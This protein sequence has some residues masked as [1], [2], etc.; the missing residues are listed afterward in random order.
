[1]PDVVIAGAGPAG[2]VAATVLA[3]AGVDVLLVDRAR[4]PRDKLCGDTINPGALAI[5]RRLGLAHRPERTAIRLEGMVVTGGPGV[6]VE[7]RYGR[8]R[9]GCAI[10]RRDLDA[11]LLAAAA[12][13]GATVEEG[14]SVRAAI[15]EEAAGRAVVRGVVVSGRL[16]RDL[17]LPARLTIAADGRRSTLAFGLGLAW[18]PRAPRRWAVGGYFEGVAGLGACGEMHVRRGWYLGVAPL[19]GGIANACLVTAETR[20]LDQPARRL[21]EAIAGDAALRERFARARLVGPVRSLG[22]LAVET[23][24]AGLPGLLLAGDA[25]GFIDPMT[26]DGL[27]F[28]IAG[29]ELAARAAIEGLAHGAETAHQWLAGARRQAFGRKQR[30]DRALRRLVASPRAVAAAAGLA[31]LLPVLVRY[32]VSVAGDVAVAAEA[33]RRDRSA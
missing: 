23:R 24:G 1:M 17:R 22:P 6:A 20:G 19:P 9:Y 25:A 4:F 18:H 5:L 8:G 14:V 27:R 11:A 12:A 3:R 16:G 15:V 21:R 26:G 7:G 2:A 31:R 30:F 28:A 10:R 29:G 13:A 32:A 33:D